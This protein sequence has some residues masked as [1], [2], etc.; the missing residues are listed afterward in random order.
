MYTGRTSQKYME[1]I[2]KGARAGKVGYNTG[3]EDSVMR[4][5]PLDLDLWQGSLEL[6]MTC[7]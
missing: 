3:L 2:L 6:V 4:Q 1:E 5:H 7:C